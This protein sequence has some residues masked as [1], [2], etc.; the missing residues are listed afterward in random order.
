MINLDSALGLH[1]QAIELRQKRAELIANN[2]ANSDTPGFKAR[3]IDFAKELSRAISTPGDQND[4]V[5][6]ETLM[7]RT[8]ISTSLNGNTVDTQLETAAYTEN[9]IQYEA[10]INF[11]TGKMRS[12]MTAIRGE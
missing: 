8:P 10:S 6:T 9:A 3:D 11:L 7:Y 2:I 1:A 5:N 4:A 12:L